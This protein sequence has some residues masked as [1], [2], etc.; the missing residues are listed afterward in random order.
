MT[1]SDAD[2]QVAR[3]QIRRLTVK[4][5]LAFVFDDAGGGEFTHKNFGRI[6]VPFAD[7]CEDF[8][9]LATW[10]RDHGLYV[11]TINEDQ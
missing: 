1:A 11:S 6:Q 5:D 8:R 3:D 4:H 7:A 10:L 9:L 2:Q